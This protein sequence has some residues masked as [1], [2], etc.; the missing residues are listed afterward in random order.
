MKCQY[1]YPYMFI[2]YLSILYY[3]YIYVQYKKNLELTKMYLIVL[4]SESDISFAIHLYGIL[5]I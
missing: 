4:G 1:Q 2:S 3:F 5:T